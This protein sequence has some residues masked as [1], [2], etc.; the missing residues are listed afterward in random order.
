MRCAFLTALCGLALS[1]GV[2]RYVQ[3]QGSPSE[4]EVKAAFLYNFAAFVEWPDEAT[5]QPFRIGIMSVDPPP[6]ITAVLRGRT[7]VGRAIELRIFRRVE[8]VT[9]V[10]VLFITADAAVRLNAAL[11]RL[12]GGAVLVVGESE[13]FARHGGMINFYLENDRVRFEINRGAAEAAGLRLSSQLLRI[14]RLVAGGE[15]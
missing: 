6:E 13:G 14:A 12:D 5:S 7:V 10:D 15:E 4:Y 3:A 1:A 8:D 9:S 11:Q 2:S